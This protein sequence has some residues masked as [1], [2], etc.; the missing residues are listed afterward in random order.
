MRTGGVKMQTISQPA[1]PGIPKKRK[2][3]REGLVL[4]LCALPFAAFVLAFNYVPLY[5]WIY[6]FFNYKPGIPLSSTPFVGLKY[7]AMMISDFKN[8]LMVFENTFAMSFLGI[9]FSPFPILFAILLTEIPSKRFKKLVQTTT[10]LPNFISWVIVFSLAFN[11]F[12]SD[13]LLNTI[14][15]NLHLISRSTNIL[16][17]ENATWFFQLALQLWKNT[18]WSAIIYIAAIAGIDSELFDAASVDGAGRFNKIIHV[19]IPGLMPTYFVLL[20]LQVSNFLSNGV[21]QYL[22]FYN[23]MV[24]DKITVLDYYVYRVGMVINNYS[25]GTAIG[26]FKTLVSLALLFTVNGISKRVRGASII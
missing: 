7:F 5:G 18:G 2:L 24:A 10:T 14:L 3:R 25:Y 12:S 4:L 6:A 21:D 19:T 8:T 17:N 22:A 1:M 13:G 9:L 15:K 20:L 11:L 26:I 16:G 23:S